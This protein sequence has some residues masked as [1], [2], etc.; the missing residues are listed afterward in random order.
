MLKLIFK[1][2]LMVSM[3]DGAC[4]KLVDVDPQKGN[5]IGAFLNAHSDTN[6]TAQMD[7]GHKI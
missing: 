6:D 5:Y 1:L 4:V 3:V 2:C 7:E